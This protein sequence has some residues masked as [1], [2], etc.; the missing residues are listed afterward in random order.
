MH[1]VVDTN[2][3][4]SGLLG[5][6]TCR[7][8]FLSFKEQRFELVISEILFEELKFVLDRPKFR[9]LI[10][11]GEKKE[12]I[13]FIKSHAIFV[14]PKEKVDICRDAKDNKVLEC[15]LE[16]KCDCIV[17]GDKDLLVLKS[18]RGIPVIST[19]KFLSKLFLS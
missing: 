11:S 2:I 18:F 14:K 13:S 12:A 1:A 7:K 6:D 5:S 16:A 15:A 8:V 3:F 17:S 10:K 9:L 19:T 4:I